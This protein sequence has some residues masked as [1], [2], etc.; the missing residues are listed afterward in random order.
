MFIVTDHINGWIHAKYSIGIL[1][2]LTK[3]NVNTRKR[4]VHT[5]TGQGQFIQLSYSSFTQ[6]HGKDVAEELL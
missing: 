6:T 2:G 1:S 5:L 4:H 3:P